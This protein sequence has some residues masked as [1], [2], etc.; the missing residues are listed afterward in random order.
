MKAKKVR[1]GLAQRRKMWDD[2]RDGAAKA[3][4]KRPGSLN[5]KKT[6]GASK[7]RKRSR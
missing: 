3:A 1:E 6:G 2:M 4:T 5:A 7:G